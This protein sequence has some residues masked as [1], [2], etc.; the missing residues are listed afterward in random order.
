MTDELN[1]HTVKQDTH[2]LK[3]LKN[4]VNI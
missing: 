1:K 2:T 3:S 4:L